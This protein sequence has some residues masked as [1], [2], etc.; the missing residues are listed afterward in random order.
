MRISV[1][2]PTFNRREDTSAC[3]RS[4]CDQVYDDLEIIVVDDCS[5]D[6]TAEY[7][8]GSYPAITVLRNEVNMGPSVARDR[9]ARAATGELL[10]FIDADA[11]FHDIHA[12][13]AVRALC[14]RNSAYS[15]FAFRILM[16]DGSDDT[17]R[18]WHRPAVAAWSSRQF[19]TGYVSGTCFA[20]R[21]A[22][23]EIA[24]G[25]PHHL[26]MFNEEV[27]LCIR[28]VREG[29]RILYSPV[30]AVVHK[31]SSVSRNTRI[32][33]ELKRRNQILMVYAYYPYLTGVLFLLPRL[34]ST[35]LEAIREGEVK[36]YIASIFDAFRV[37]RTGSVNR[38]VLARP[39]QRRLR[40]L[41]YALP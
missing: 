23:Y 26:F 8:Q 37:I 2:V 18:W 17:G 35:L 22:D 29:M 27:E 39:V 19:E 21:S 31:V 28:M 3:V 7:L 30:P 40:K 15:C 9:G 41:S 12:I 25:F 34:L 11:E 10:V 38:A 1:I 4:L 24:G 13:S 33:F 14:S 32:N 16:S 20:V 5:S 36:R 6:G